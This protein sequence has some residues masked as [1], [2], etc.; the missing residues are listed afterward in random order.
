VNVGDNSLNATEVSNHHPCFSWIS[1]FALLSVGF[2]CSPLTARADNCSVDSC[3]SYSVTGSLQ[4]GGSLS[5]SFV[6]DES[7][8]TIASSSF[9]A[10]GTSFSSGLYYIYQF[11]A[12]SGPDVFN[13]FS[14]GGSELSIQFGPFSL[15]G[16]PNSFSLS[17]T[18]HIDPVLGAWVDLNSGV[19]IA[20]PES[21]S[22]LFALVGALAIIF[23]GV[24]SDYRLGRE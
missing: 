20:T 12:P 7:N 15:T 5:G 3:V 24:R 10:G 13:A 8:G 18:T 21:A 2:L 16:L 9:L 23:S 4:D 6:V 14:T 17:G 1:V 11:P 19:A 22:W